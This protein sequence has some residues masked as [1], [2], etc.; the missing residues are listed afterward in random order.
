MINKVSNHLLELEEKF[1]ELIPRE[2]ELV[3][4]EL[5]VLEQDAAQVL[6]SIVSESDPMLCRALRAAHKAQGEVVRGVKVGGN[7]CVRL[8]P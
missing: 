6:P 2:E 7:E 1:P 4:E 3:L 5:E 8:G